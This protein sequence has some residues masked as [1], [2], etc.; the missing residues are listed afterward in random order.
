[1]PSR[2]LLAT[3]MAIGGAGIA[4]SAPAAVLLAAPGVAQAAPPPAADPACPLFGSCNPPS[5]GSAVASFAG[6]GNLADPFGVPTAFLSL[7]G[8]IPIVN[9]FIGNGADGTAAHPDGFNGGIFA[10]NG[11]SSAKDIGGHPLS[12][13]AQAR[14]Q[15]RAELGRH[16]SQSDP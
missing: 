5:V 11:G 12:G 2:P 13:P 8:A 3:A 16:L 10:C 14:T 15:L 7:A 6:P 4:L 9:V 1:M